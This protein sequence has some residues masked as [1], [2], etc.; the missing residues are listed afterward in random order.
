MAQSDALT[1]PSSAGEAGRRSRVDIRSCGASPACTRRCARS[2]SSL[3]R[4]F[5]R[6]HRRARR[7][8]LPRPARARTVERPRREPRGAPASLVRIPEPAGAGMTALDRAGTIGN[9]SQSFQTDAINADNELGAH[10]RA[11]DENT[12]TD[13]RLDLAESQLV[14]ELAGPLHRRRR[15]ERSPGAAARLRDRVVVGR[16]DPADGGPPR[17]DRGGDFTK[18]VSVANRDELGALAAN[19]N[20]MWP[21]I[22]P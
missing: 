2:C 11:R 12:G 14:H 7:G 10:R 20:R 17:G 18:H 6:H 15:G 22:T 8:R 16:P 19:V 21:S 9:K 4:R 1:R 13:E 5:R 3:A